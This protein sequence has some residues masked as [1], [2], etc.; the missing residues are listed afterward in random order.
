MKTE[1]LK[2]TVYG[3]GSPKLSGRCILNINRLLTHHSSC[4]SWATQLSG[5]AT[6]ELNGNI[7]I[8][9]SVLS[10]TD[11]IKKVKKHMFRCVMITVLLSTAKHQNNHFAV[12]KWLLH[13]MMLFWVSVATESKFS[14]ILTVKIN[15]KVTENYKFCIRYLKEHQFEEQPFLYWIM[16]I[17]MF[18]GWQKHC[19]H[20]TPNM[21]FLT[22]ESWVVWENLYNSS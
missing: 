5:G 16:I 8:A 18:S 11:Q 9:L 19:N 15:G 12:L 17:L 1:N 21:C 2:V 3:P 13:K 22:V 14:V 10:Q 4:Q 20:D 7:Y 6:V